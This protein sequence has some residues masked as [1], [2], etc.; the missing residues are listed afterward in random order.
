ME[1]WL[2]NRKHPENSVLLHFGAI[3]AYFLV[4]TFLFSANFDNKVALV[5]Q[6]VFLEPIFFTSILLHIIYS[7]LFSIKKNISNILVLAQ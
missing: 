7:P 1:N 5:R 2:I 4:T 3:L 6:M